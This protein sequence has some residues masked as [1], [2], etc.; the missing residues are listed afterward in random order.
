MNRTGASHLLALAA[1]A[2]IPVDVCQAGAGPSSTG[3]AEPIARGTFAMA[4]RLGQIARGA[5]PDVFEWT[6]AARAD[7]IRAKLAEVT[8]LREAV[9]ARMQ[10]YMNFVGPLC[11][12]GDFCAGQ[13][14]S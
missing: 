14:W 6:N 1:V 12:S 13:D 9:I 7:Y 2:L 8:N 10:L 5:G 11:W 4:E 3:A